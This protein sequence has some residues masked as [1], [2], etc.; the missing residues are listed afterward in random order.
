MKEKKRLVG[1]AEKGNEI[2]I[3]EMGNTYY[4]HPPFFSFALQSLLVYLE[5]DGQLAVCHTSH[6]MLSTALF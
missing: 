2:Q 5:D 3:K 6:A 4:S 1:N